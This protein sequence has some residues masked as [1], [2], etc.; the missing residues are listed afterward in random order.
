MDLSKIQAKLAALE[1]K[2]KSNANNGQPAAHKLLEWKPTPG[3][4]DKSGTPTEA[5]YVIRILPNFHIG[6]D[7]L[8]FL[9]VDFYYDFGRTWLSPSQF[10]E[11]D[12]IADFYQELVKQYRAETDKARNKE[13]WQMSLKFK[14]KD[15]ICVP[16]L[17]RGE[18]DKGVKFWWFSKKL[19]QDIKQIT[20]DSDYG[21]IFDLKKGHDI[22][23]SYKPKELTSTGYPEISVLPKPKPTPV[24]DDSEVLNAV[25]NMPNILEAFTKPTYEETKA[26][27]EAYL[28]QQSTPAPEA[29]ATS[30]DDT[31]LKEINDIPVGAKSSV[32]EKM[33]IDFDALFDEDEK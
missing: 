12:A 21:N 25:K 16:V 3:P 1:T 17:V 28:K 2:V 31:F 24:S 23:V 11:P 20:E 5:K 15:R 26:G 9:P 7:E 18:E 13:L 27:L 4:T 19:Y 32:V 29:P 6:K 30:K 8:P 14:P 10:D 33:D 22:T